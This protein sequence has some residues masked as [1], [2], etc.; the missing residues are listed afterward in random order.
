MVA[1]AQKPRAWEVKTRGSLGLWRAVL[2][3]AAGSGPMKD[4][5]QKK[6]RREEE[7]EEEEKERRR[8]EESKNS[9]TD[10]NNTRRTTEVV[11]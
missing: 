8:K 11:P 9:K 10:V 4:Q 1:C 5:D 7:V 6:K 3:K 2:G